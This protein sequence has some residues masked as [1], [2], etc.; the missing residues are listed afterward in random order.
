[1]ELQLYYLQCVS[2]GYLGNSPMLWRKGGAGYTQWLDEAEQMTADEINLIVRGSRGSH[3]WKR[4]K[5][6]V[7]DKIALRTVDMQDVPK[8]RKNPKPEVSQWVRALGER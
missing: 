4:W 7:F 8:R 6:E 2:K 1:M 5:V 3:K